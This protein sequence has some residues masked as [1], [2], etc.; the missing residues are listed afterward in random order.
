MK[1]LILAA[2]VFAI[3]APLSA[4]ADT[5]AEA[6]AKAA[7]G[8]A[9]LSGSQSGASNQTTFTS[10]ANTTQRIE[11][12]GGYDLKTVPNIAIGGPA[13]GPCNGFSAGLGVSVMGAAVMGNMSKV[14]E[15]CEERE[16][17]RIAALMGRMDIANL[18]IENTEVYQRALKRKQ[19]A[20]AQPRKA[21][22]PQAQK[23]AMTSAAPS[24]QEQSVNQCSYA[25]ASGDTFLAAR[26]CPK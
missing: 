13:S 3:L 2:A 23:V 12:A 7:A 19:D 20:A 5:E 16:T 25:K 11:H 9:A 18:I 6:R 8:A 21:E 10:P 26:V 22:A 4:Q 1:Q 24:A 17:A 14:D 15:G